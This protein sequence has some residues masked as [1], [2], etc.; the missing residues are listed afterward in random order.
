SGSPQEREAIG[1]IKGRLEEYG[2]EPQLHWFY[3]YISEPKYARLRVLSPREIEVQCTPYRQVGSTGPEGVEGEVVYLSPEEIGRVECRDKIV[4]AEQRVAGEWMGLRDGLLLRLQRMGVK[5]LIVV[6]QD[7][8]MPT[9]CHQRADFSVSGNPTPENVGEI[10]TIPA[11]VHVSNKD[12]ELLKA[13]AKGGGMRVHIV[14]I[15]E[16]GWRRLPLLTAEIRGEDPERFLLVHGHVDTPPFSPG[17]TD[18]A[19]GVTAMLEM[20]RILNRYKGHLRRSV[21]F[22]FWTGHE[23]GRYAGSTWYNDAFW[24][25]LR[26]RCVGCLNVDSPGAEGATTYRAVGVGELEEVAKESI[27]AVKGVE[28]EERRWPTRAGDSSF[29]GTGLPQTIVV[30]ARPKDLYDPFVNYSGGGWWW[31]T[32]YATMEHGDVDI[33][34]MDVKVNLNFI[35]RMTNC[36]ILPLNFAP[37]AEEMVRV[38]EEIQRKAEKVRPYFHID[39][40]IR[41][42]EEFRELT[43]RLEETAKKLVERG[44]PQMEVELLNRCLL[45]VS[46]HINPVAHSNAEKTGQMSME[47]FGRVPFQR[48]H[49]VVKLAEMTLP[50]S[51]EF[52]LLRTKL[53]R[54]RNYVE[55]GFYQANNLI[56]ETLERLGLL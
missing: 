1:F 16:T 42:A 20:A 53:M 10:Q 43:G 8:Y 9:V 48:I 41:R 36:P 14:S 18:N 37:Y 11:I 26:Y 33:L 22:A 45:W 34:A 15:V 13:M 44:L 49:D 17:V 50:Y 19:S 56:R 12:G 21:R 54:Q 31:H 25:D 40:V 30:S 24:F 39:P 4:L 3:A 55:D 32:P 23:I 6:E 35:W 46:R 27:R 51:E 5:G 7:S 28:V 52:Y 47:Y 38:L 29:W 2:L